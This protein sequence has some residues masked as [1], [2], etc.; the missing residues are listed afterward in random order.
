MDSLTQAISSIGEGFIVTDKQGFITFMNSSAEK[1]TGWRNC[2]AIDKHFDEIFQIIDFFTKESLVSPIQKT[3]DNRSTFGLQNYTALVKKDGEVIFVSANCSA[4]C[5]QNKE[6]EGVAVVFRDIDRIKHVEEDIRREKNNLKNVLEA[7]P[8]AILIV[9]KSAIIRWENNRL[10]HM[11]HLEGSYITGFRFG[12]V[13]N[14][15][16]S[17]E[18]GCSYGPHCNSCVIIKAINDAILDGHQKKDMEIQYSVAGQNRI[19]SYW[20]RINTIPLINL[21]E[22]EVLMFIE[23][24]TKQ[25]EYEEHLLES[26]EAAE[27]ANRARNEFLTNMTHELRTPLHGIIGMSELLLSSGLDADQEENAHMIKVC[28]SGL[29]QIINDL[30]DAAKI[31]AGKLDI[32]NLGFEFIAVIDESI[33]LFSVMAQNKHLS[34]EYSISPEIP[35]ILKGD[36]KRL[37]QIIDNLISNAVKFTHSGGVR[38]DV[39]LLSVTNQTVEINFKVS[40]TGI[41]ISDINIDRLFQRFSQI[42]GSK[43]REFG[44]SGLGLSICKQLVDIMKGDIGVASEKGKGSTFYFTLSFG[45]ANEKVKDSNNNINHGKL[46]I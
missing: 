35:K 24:I 32:V 41:G 29:L 10:Q 20:I 36:P 14:C 21:K 43:T 3:L 30:L 46:I 38:F 26:K 8:Q 19:E 15:L 22:N 6:I 42:D 28:A 18:D 7:L 11:F 37:R 13:T 27:G 1:L 5:S 25:R 45:I 12:D 39:E 40:D 9:D 34:F 2:D 17:F 44:G 16:N 23:D 4:I 31:E 33:K